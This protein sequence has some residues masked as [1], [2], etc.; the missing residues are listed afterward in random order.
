MS[1]RVSVALA[2]AAAC[3]I[4]AAGAACAQDDGT[5]AAGPPRG[6]PGPM[7]ETPGPG[8]MGPGG[9][10]G[11][12][13]MGGHGPM[14]GPHGPGGPRSTGG[15][16][17][18]MGPHGP[19]PADWEALGLSE[20][21]RQRLEELQDAEA[22]KVIRVEADLRLAE[23][24]LRRLVSGARPDLRAIG[25]QVDRMADLRAEIMKAR[26]TT[27]VRMREILASGPSAGPGQRRPGAR[28]DGTLPERRPPP[29]DR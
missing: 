25:E 21:Q 5:G 20:E 10:S 11:P 22:R 8:C 28:P 24:D 18:M 6:E 26:L 19:G 9:P 4:A 16:G 14:M 15:H 27:R 23:L 13:W 12:P 2:L 1:R 3:L 17:P 29:P 7:M